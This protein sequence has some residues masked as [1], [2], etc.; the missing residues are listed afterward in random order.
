VSFSLLRLFQ[1]QTSFVLLT[2]LVSAAQTLRVAAHI[3]RKFDDRV[4]WLYPAI[5]STSQAPIDEMHTLQSAG[6][7]QLAVPPPFV[8]TPPFSLRT[9]SQM[10]APPPLIVLVLLEQW[11]A[12]LKSKRRR[13]RQESHVRGRKPSSKCSLEWER[14]YQWRI[15]CIGL[16]VPEDEFS[17][18]SMRHHLGR[19]Q[20]LHCDLVLYLESADGPQPVLVSMRRC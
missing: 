20:Y 18:Q 11:M 14:K 10:P 6:V 7:S 3:P 9:V 2:I 15:S 17:L 16:T 8:R 4:P 1:L 5:L 12:H 13:S 19:W